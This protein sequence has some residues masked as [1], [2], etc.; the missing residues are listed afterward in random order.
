MLKEGTLDESVSEH[1]ATQSTVTELLREE[2]HLRSRTSEGQTW[3]LSSVLKI[4]AVKKIFNA[5][6]EIPFIK[7][8]GCKSSHK[9]DVSRSEDCFWSK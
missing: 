7:K 6:M 2:A 1:K 9:S 5:L 4:E 3:G 8:S